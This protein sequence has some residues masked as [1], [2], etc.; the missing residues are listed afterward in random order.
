MT[1]QSLARPPSREAPNMGNYAASYRSLARRP[2]TNA[3]PCL[4]N[5]LTLVAPG[6]LEAI[7]VRHGTR[8]LHIL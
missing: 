2:H 8:E 4:S 7:M 6:G 1:P 5:H 3:S